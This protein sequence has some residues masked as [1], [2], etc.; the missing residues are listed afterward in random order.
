MLT[1]KV[2]KSVNKSD[3][4]A[5]KMKTRANQPCWIIRLAQFISLESWKCLFFFFFSV[6]YY[7]W[8]NQKLEIKIKTVCDCANFSIRYCFIGCSAIALLFYRLLCLES[9]FQLAL[10]ICHNKAK[11]AKIVRNDILPPAL[12]Q[13]Q[14]ARVNCIVQNR[15]NIHVMEVSF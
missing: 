8:W 13:M 15:L 5:W 2:R 1:F 6:W 3:L 4:I 14:T 11:L 10:G 12:I 9:P 7:D